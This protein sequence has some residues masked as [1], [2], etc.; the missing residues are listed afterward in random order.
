MKKSNL[1]FILVI[2][3][4]AGSTTFGYAQDAVTIGTQT[5]MKKNLDV[6]KYRNGDVIPEVTD[7]SAWANLTTGAWCYYENKTK[8]GTNYGKLYNWYA[9]NDPRGLAPKG[10]HIPNEEEWTLLTNQL[11]G[12]DSAGGKMKETGSTHWKSPNTAA[13][14]SSGWEGLPGGYRNDK[15]PFYDLGGSGKWWSSTEGGYYSYYAWVRQLSFPYGFIGRYAFK[16]RFGFSVR[17][18][19]D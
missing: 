1:T 5:W 19:R 15:G 2:L 14:N 12:E 18:I 16:K 4:L 13:T 10:W 7:P 6:S 8:N 9:V 11:G 17:C 3:L